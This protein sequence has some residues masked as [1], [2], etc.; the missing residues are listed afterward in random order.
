MSTNAFETLYKI[1]QSISERWAAGAIGASTVGALAVFLYMLDV[2]SLGW[3]CT[4][5]LASGLG[6]GTCWVRWSRSRAEERRYYGLFMQRAT[7]DL[8]RRRTWRR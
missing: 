1:Q 5:A 6:C 3:V 7:N 4:I 8:S 2:L